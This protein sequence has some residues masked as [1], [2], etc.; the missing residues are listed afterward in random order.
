MRVPEIGRAGQDKLSQATA[1][2]IGLGALGSVTADLL[3]RAG[4]GRLVLI[5]RDIVEW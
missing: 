4:V 3:A 2:L 1:C 5:D